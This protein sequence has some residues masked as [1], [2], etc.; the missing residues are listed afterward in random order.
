MSFCSPGVS[1]SSRMVPEELSMVPISGAPTKHWGASGRPNALPP[2]AESVPT[3]PATM[4]PLHLPLTSTSRRGAGAP[5]RHEPVQLLLRPERPARVD[6]AVAVGRLAG[7]R[8]A[9]AGRRL[10][11]RGAV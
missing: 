1:C 3:P 4:L 9:G 5:L 7:R 2:P 10:H 11:Q 6:L 8:I